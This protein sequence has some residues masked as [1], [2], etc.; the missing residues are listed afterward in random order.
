MEN[1][2]QKPKV[3]KFD[4]VMWSILLTVL[5]YVIVYHFIAPIAIWKYLIIE[6]MFCASIRCAKWLS[7]R[8]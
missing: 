5:C 4:L 3:N 8:P 6:I 1:I 7:E 2:E